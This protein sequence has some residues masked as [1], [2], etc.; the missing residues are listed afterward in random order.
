MGFF[1]DMFKDVV[2]SGFDTTLK[3]IDKIV[4]SGDASSDLQGNISSGD[5]IDHKTARDI[6]DKL[7][8]GC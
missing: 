1:G 6:K 8:R 3:D 2:S 5:T 4:K 7:D